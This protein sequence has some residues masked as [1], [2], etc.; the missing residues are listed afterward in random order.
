MQEKKLQLDNGNRHRKT[1]NPIIDIQEIEVKES[2]FWEELQK[3][4]TKKQWKWVQYTFIAQLSV[5]EIME[6]EG[7]SSFAVKAW[8][9][10]VRR[11]LRNDTALKERLE[12]LQ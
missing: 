9:A 11:K 7:V 10:E 12:S 5:K 2:A 1:G 8:G 4:L 6:I 3:R